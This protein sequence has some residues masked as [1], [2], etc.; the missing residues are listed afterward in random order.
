MVRKE[1]VVI[2]VERADDDRAFDLRSFRLH[3]THDVDE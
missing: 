3:P 2:E 1:G